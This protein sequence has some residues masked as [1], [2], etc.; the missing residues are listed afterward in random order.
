MGER[1]TKHTKL[2]GLFACPMGHSHFPAMYNEAFAAMGLDYVY[3]AFEVDDRG[4]EA[5]VRAIGT[6]NMR[7]A[8]VAAPGKTTVGKYLDSLSPAARLS[9]VVDTIVNE[10]GHLIG[11]NTDGA[12]FVMALKNQ[13]WDVAGKKLT[14]VGAGE[15]AAA[16]GIQAALEGA[17]EI[18]VFNARDPL[19]CRAKE[20]VKKINEYTACR[21]RLYPLESLTELRR[22][23]EESSLFVDGTETEAAGA[24]PGERT[25][26]KIARETGCRTVNGLDLM[27]FG[28]AAAF[29]LWTG[30]PMPIQ[31]M[32]HV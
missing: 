22:E 5:A 7:G 13:G 11:Y 4:M 31:H 20:T 19:W 29:E 12:G 24:W 16:I 14:I 8:H 18:S 17:G 28:A 3:L 25:V 15:A 21:A 2:I 9:G 30:K 32:R 26:A 1:I 6:L 23:M 27:M 10:K